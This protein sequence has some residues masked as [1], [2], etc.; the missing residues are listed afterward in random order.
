MRRIARLIRRH[1]I[2]VSLAGESIVSTVMGLLMAAGLEG[3]SVERLTRNQGHRATDS[4]SIA[5]R[6]S[7]RQTRLWVICASILFTAQHSAVKW[8]SPFRIESLSRPNL[9]RL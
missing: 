9:V 1:H 4:K 6:F 2:F 8:T 5:G 7:L 3:A